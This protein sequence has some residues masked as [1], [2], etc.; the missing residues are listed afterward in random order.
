MRKV[1]ISF[2]LALSLF[3][4]VAPVSFASPATTQHPVPRLKA[5]EHQRMTLGNK[6][7]YEKDVDLLDPDLPGLAVELSVDGLT[8]GDL[9]VADN[10]SVE[11]SGTDDGHG[12]L[13]K[14]YMI[15]YVVTDVT[16]TGRGVLKLLY[17]LRDPAHSEDKT[18]YVSTDVTFGKPYVYTEA[19][20]TRIAVTVRKQ[21]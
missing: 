3:A 15:S 2:L 11:R 9:T 12:N 21:P 7:V 6:V 8:K 18:G 19:D 4:G 1:Q 20:G 16:P 13:L 14:G 17:T 5:I 10:I